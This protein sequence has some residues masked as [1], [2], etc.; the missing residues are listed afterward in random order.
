M[1]RRR[2]TTTASA[3][4]RSTS[5][6]YYEELG[7][8]GL[9]DRSSRP[10]HS[11]KATGSEVV[12]RIVYLRQHYCFGPLKIAMYL[13]RYHDIQMSKSGVWRILD[14]LG[15]GRLPANQRY[16]RH[17]QRWKCYERPQHVHQVQ[18]DVV[19]RT[20]SRRDRQ[21]ALPVHRHRRLHPHPGAA[22]LPQVQPDHCH[23]VPRL[24]PRAAP[25]QGRCDPDRQRRRVPGPASA[26]TFWTGASATA[27]SS[28]RRRG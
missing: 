17:K 15:M 18:I 20:H 2:A 3:G 7:E 13:K 5:S 1:W 21:E 26:G 9:R 6:Y 28:P 27:T 8:K 25:V 19:H 23:R 16:K 11:L 4:R 14:R 10:H 24:P 12:V 22:H